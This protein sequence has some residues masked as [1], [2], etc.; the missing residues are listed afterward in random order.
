[1]T[2]NF[3]AAITHK[4]DYVMNQLHNCHRINNIRKSE[5]IQSIFHNAATRR[6]EGRTSLECL[7]QMHR[8]T[9]IYNTPPLRMEITRSQLLAVN[10]KPACIKRLRR[11]RR[12]S[13]SNPHLLLVLVLLVNI[14]RAVDYQEEWEEESDVSLQYS[15]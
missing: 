1:M 2:E 6:R 7:H 8:A 13:A 11:L 10:Q 12:P 3:L 4:L 14:A 5:H 9:E 15:P